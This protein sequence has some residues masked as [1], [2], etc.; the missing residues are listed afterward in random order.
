MNSHF[1]GSI[2]CFISR[3]STPALAFPTDPVA[4]WSHGL[5]VFFV[6]WCH[7]LRTL[8]VNF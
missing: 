2:F 6:L 4:L 1:K 3:A 8:K 5:V 7:L